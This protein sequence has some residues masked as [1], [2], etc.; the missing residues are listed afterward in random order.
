MPSLPLRTLA[1]A[2]AALWFL[3]GP[4]AAKYSITTIARPGD[5]APVGG[6]YDV[7]NNSFQGP[8][9]SGDVVFTATLTGAPAAAIFL[10]SGGSTSALVTAGTAAP[11]S[12]GTFATFP[13]VSINDNGDIAFKATINGGSVD[14][15]FFRKS[16]P[17]ITAVALTGDAAP[18]TPP[19]TYLVGSTSTLASI[20]SSGDVNFYS[21]LSGGDSFEGIFVDSAGTDSKIAVDGDTAPGTGGDLITGFVSPAPWPR[22]LTDSGDVVFPAYH[23][24]GGPMMA[25]SLGVFRYSGGSLSDEILSGDP[26]AC[27]TTAA[28]NF[29]FDVNAGGDFLFW[30]FPSIHQ[31][32][33]AGEETRIVSS[34]DVAADGGVH[35]IPIQ[36]SDLSDGQDVLFRSTPEPALTEGLYVYDADAGTDVLVVQAG[37]PVPGLGG[38]SFASFDWFTMAVN[39]ND[40]VVFVAALSDLSS[41]LFLAEGGAPGPLDFFDPRGEGLDVITYMRTVP[42][43]TSGGPGYEFQMGRYEVTVGQFLEFLNEAEA[44]PGDERGAFLVFDAS[45][46]VGI[47][48]AAT[49][50]VFDFSLN[51]PSRCLGYDATK[52]LGSRYSHTPLGASQPIVGVSWIGAV[53]F[54]NWLTL[55]HGMLPADRCYTE[56]NSVGDWHPVSI[57]TGGWAAG[58]LNAAQRLALVDGP[59]RCPGFR[60]PMDNVVNSMFNHQANQENAYNERYEAAAHSNAA[61][62]FGRMD[63]AVAISADYWF[64][65]FGEDSL[66]GADTNYLGSGDPLDDA[67]TAVGFYD[68][69]AATNREQNAHVIFDL[70]GNVAEWGQDQNTGPGDRRVRFGSFLTDATMSGDLLA[71]YTGRALAPDQ[72]FADVGFR[73]VRLPPG[74]PGGGSQPELSQAYTITGTS[75]GVGWSWGIDNGLYSGQVPPVAPGGSAAQLVSKWVGSVNNVGKDCNAATGGAQSSSMMAIYV[76]AFFPGTTEFCVGPYGSVP[77]S[78]SPDPDVCCM[79]PDG[80]CSFNPTVTPVEAKESLTG[81]AQGG[82]VSALVDGQPAMITTSAGEHSGTVAENLAAAIRDQTSF[83]AVALNGNVFVADVA[84]E[85][86]VVT[87]NDPGLHIVSVP[88]LDLYGGAL[89]LAALMLASGGLALARG[90][91]TWL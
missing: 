68:G 62:P 20:N 70:A 38:L 49:D 65:A 44:N 24:I 50:S 91:R 53:K 48:G 69:T 84:L 90:R 11:E 33:A 30:N 88:S 78:N 2:A 12:G 66:S 58:D 59:D 76:R 16:G 63:P 47:S 41:G 32:T 21:R 15:G 31:R 40:Q 27:G 86:F 43:S 83:N 1:L 80:F 74:C 57:S 85:D 9:N 4:A 46:D 51:D 28:T 61:P 87:V 64:Y 25:S 22:S 60:L 89:L 36:L 77:T 37:D 45:G 72:G 35:R 7:I 19:G 75:T 29:P 42:A 23:G 14:E 73:V 82:S 3:A 10:Y 67:D 8:N 34:G 6:S 81:I 54:S 13:S 18:V 52:P 56:G 55:R 26:L 5:P 17:T 71:S 39:A 79:P